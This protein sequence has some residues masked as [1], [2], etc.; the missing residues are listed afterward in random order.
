MLCHQG[1]LLIERPFFQ[2]MDFPTEGS[3]VLAGGYVPVL[4]THSSLRMDM[5]SQNISLLA[6]HAIATSSL[7]VFLGLAGS[8]SRY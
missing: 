5:I 3:L 4:A 7:Q 8:G 1:V 2:F 6:N